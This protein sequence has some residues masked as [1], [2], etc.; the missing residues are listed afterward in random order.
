MF[1]FARKLFTSFFILLH[2]K[3]IQLFDV[4][5]I[6]FDNIITVGLVIEFFVIRL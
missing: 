2:G 5:G 4:V 6:N 1:C 3:K